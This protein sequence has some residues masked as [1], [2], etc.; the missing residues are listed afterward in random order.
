M[1]NGKVTWLWINFIFNVFVSFRNRFFVFLSKSLYCLCITHSYNVTVFH[2]IICY[3]RTRLNVSRFVY[4]LIHFLNGLIID[5]IYY[6]CLT[7]WMHPLRHFNIFL[8]LQDTNM[9]VILYQYG[10]TVFHSFYFIS[11]YDFLWHIFNM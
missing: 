10:C 1:L 8:I 11:I 5:F 6:Y 2:K 4:F 7:I 3:S 9:W